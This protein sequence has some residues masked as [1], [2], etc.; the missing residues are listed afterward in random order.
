MTNNAYFLSKLCEKMPERIT[1]R[2]A[3]VF[4]M[5]LLGHTMVQI[6]QL[7]YISSRT[8][9]T[10]MNHVK[11]KIQLRRRE[12]ILQFLIQFDLYDDFL[13]LAKQLLLTLEVESLDQTQNFYRLAQLS[14]DGLPW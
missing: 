2:E 10:H 11:D 7:L 9:E 13:M 3:Q 14:N 5:W 1:W 6:G 12:E 8:V 4:S